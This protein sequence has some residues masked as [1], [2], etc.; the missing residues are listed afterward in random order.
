MSLFAPSFDPNF[1]PFNGHRSPNIQ[2]C[3]KVGFE[4]FQLGRPRW[5]IDLHDQSSG[6]EFEWFDMTTNGLADD[7]GPS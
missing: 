4:K 2:T 6:V 5:F 7:F 1:E 3:Q